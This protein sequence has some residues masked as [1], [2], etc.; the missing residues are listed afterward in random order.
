MRTAAQ[1]DPRIKTVTVTDEAIVAH[2]VDGRAIS[3]PLVWSW[4]LSDATPKQRAR[5]KIVADGQGIHWPDVD[6]DISLEGMLRGIPA[7]RPK[8]MAAQ[9]REERKQ[10]ALQW[11]G[12]KAASRR[13]TPRPAGAGITRA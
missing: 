12:S 9:Q 5:W 13:R 4:R 8:G 7:K 10:A 2:L 3:V 6:E 1:R 11:A